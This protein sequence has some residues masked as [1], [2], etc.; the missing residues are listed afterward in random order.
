MRPVASRSFPFA[1]ASLVLAALPAVSAANVPQVATQPSAVTVFAGSALVERRGELK[2][3]KGLHRVVLSG[4]PARLDDTSVRVTLSGEGAPHLVGF[5]VESIPAAEI[6]STEARELEAEQEGLADARK[7]IDDGRAVLQDRR[8]FVTALRATM[9]SRWTLNMA[10]A[11]IDVAAMALV[12]NHAARRLRE[13][14]ARERKLD[15]EQADNERK[16]DLVRRKLATLSSKR[17]RQTKTVAVDVRNARDGEVTVEVRYLVPGAHWRNVYDAVLEGT[18]VRF[19][20]YAIVTQQTGEDWENVVLRLSSAAAA[21]RVT[22][23]QLTAQQVSFQPPYRPRPRD[24]RRGYYKG[25]KTRGGGERP[26]TGMP[27]PMPMREEAKKEEVDVASVASVSEF[28]ATYAVDGRASLASD[29]TPRKITLGLAPTDA[30]VLHEATPREQPGATLLVRGRYK[31]E[32]PLLPGAVSLYL[33]G[34]Y[35]GESAIGFLGT[36]GELKLPFGRDDRL[37]VTRKRVSRVVHDKGVFTKD[38]KIDYEYQIDVENLVGRSV[39][40]SVRDLVP[41]STDERIKVELGEQ[42]TPPSASLPED[43]KGVLRWELNLAPGEKR[44]LKLSYSVR[45]PQT[46]P[47]TGVE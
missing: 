9:Q 23:P 30:E 6:V 37:R 8:A 5:A 22:I 35:I 33:G 32:V 39:K 26:T 10:L 34:D 21:S 31:G 7:L 29:G 38:Y 4:L 27:S 14:G 47:V 25:G 36:G 13:L 2:L 19:I 17:E 40:L 42:T 24:Y 43:N 3:P 18:S 46:L 12:H 15:L 44:E 16:Q 1:L 11:P 41:I 20:Q 45:Y 28:A